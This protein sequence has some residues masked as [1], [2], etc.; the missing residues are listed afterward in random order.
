MRLG[1]IPQ[2]QLHRILIELFLR[3]LN[4]AVLLILELIQHILKSPEQA[5]CHQDYL[6]RTCFDLAA[7]FPLAELCFYH[8]D[9]LPPIPNLLMDHQSLSCSPVVSSRHGCWPSHL[10]LGR[11]ILLRMHTRHALEE[12]ESAPALEHRNR[13]KRHGQRGPSFL[14]LQIP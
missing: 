10:S 12:D 4:G 14:T 8:N 3:D 1:N 11:I 6:A 13:N 2:Q 7:T 5:P 9:T